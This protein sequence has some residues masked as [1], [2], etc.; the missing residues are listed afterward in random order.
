MSE[1]A[2]MQSDEIEELLFQAAVQSKIRPSSAV[3][4]FS[5]NLS[6]RGLSNLTY[7]RV[8]SGGVVAGA[9]LVCTLEMNNTDS[10]TAGLAM[11]RISN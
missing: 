7:N 5:L 2:A 6:S 8:V 9:A 3:R 1:R 4:P 10:M 11:S